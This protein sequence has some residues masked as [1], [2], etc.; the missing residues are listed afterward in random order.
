M[1]THPDDRH[2]STMLLDCV[3]Q[4]GN[5]QETKRIARLALARFPDLPRARLI[6]P[7]AVA[8]AVRFGE[9]GRIYAEI[10]RAVPSHPVATLGL[11]SVASLMARGAR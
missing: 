2:G 8:Q 1:A 10:V 9:A 5:P 6:L 7:G 11:R 3:D 4:G